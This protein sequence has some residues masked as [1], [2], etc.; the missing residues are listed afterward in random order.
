MVELRG[1]AKRFDGKRQV[2]ALDGVDLVVGK[3]EMVSIVGPS[4][5]GKSTLIKL[6]IRDEVATSGDVIL[7][8]QNL[9]R[10]S[11]IKARWDPDNV[12]RTN[13]SIKPSGA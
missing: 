1:V 9:A 5:S 11:E 6:L 4:G 10:L 3:G 2:T 8:G 12:F 7:D 13:K